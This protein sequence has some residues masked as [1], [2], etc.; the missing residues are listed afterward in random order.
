MARVLYA[1]GTMPFCCPG[2]QL[3]A[4]V[5]LYCA[6]LTHCATE[7]VW[8]GD[9][10]RLIRPRA[11]IL[12]GAKIRGGEREGEVGRAR[13]GRG[14]PNIQI[15]HSLLDSSTHPTSTDS[16]S[17]MVVLFQEACT[18]GTFPPLCC[19]RAWTPARDR[20]RWRHRIAPDQ[21]IHV[22]A[23]AQS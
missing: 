16:L 8:Q 10:S 18:T 21:S 11:K 19:L 23:D 4:C 12:A 15:F 2:R 3:P 22:A 13:L 9:S 7:C 6:E 14:A 17:C 1:P 20:A 5:C